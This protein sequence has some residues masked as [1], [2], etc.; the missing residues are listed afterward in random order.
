MC[1]RDRPSFNVM[2][3]KEGDSLI[4]VSESYEGCGILMVSAL[5]LCTN[6]KIEDIP[7][8]G[9]V[10]G[11]VRGMM[12]AENDRLICADIIN[13]DGEII[14]V[15]NKGYGKRVNAFEFERMNRG[16]RGVKITEFGVNGT[17]LVFASYVTLPYD[18]AVISDEPTFVVNSE[19]I[20]IESRNHKG[21]PI[22]KCNVEK[23]LRVY[24]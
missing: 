8:Q 5:G 3:L 21:K 12:L 11:G 9:R 10:A 18:I 20:G 24:N 22:K 1:I 14:V 16:R 19:N 6:V 4:A 15:T 13:E 7:L 2:K 17:E 23:V